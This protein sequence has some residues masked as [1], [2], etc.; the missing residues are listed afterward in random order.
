MTPTTITLPDGSRLERVTDRGGRLFGVDSDTHR[1][2]TFDGDASA[3]GR[4]V[5]ADGNLV[6]DVTP[7]PTA[8]SEAV[9]GG[10]RPRGR[11]A[12][13]RPLGERWATYNQFIDVIAPRLTLAE[14]AVWHV[15]F[16]HTRGGTCQTSERAIAEQAGIDK[17]TAGRALRQLVRLRLVWAVFKSTSKGS[18]SLY[19]MHPQPAKCLPATLAMH[20]KR[21]GEARDRRHRNGG[22]RRGRRRHQGSKRTG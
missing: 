10:N 2:A 16:R 17:A 13:N 21:C 14:R 22:D 4:L 11:S 19:G 3:G 7:Q 9:P 6:R 8:A 20:D 18:P 12:G 5:D 15:M 1:T